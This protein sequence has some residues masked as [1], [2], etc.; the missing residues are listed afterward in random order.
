MSIT[1]ILTEPF[2]LRALVSALLLGPL[3]A[4]LGVFLTARRMAFF[5]DTI[6]HGAMTGIALGFW[7]GLTDPTLSMLCFSLLVAA[8]ILWL[9]EHTDLLPDTIM[10]L[11]LA[12]SVALGVVILSLL[13]G[14]YIGD[15]H[16]YLF[17]DILAVSSMD[18][19]LAAVL[20]VVIGVGVFGR[21]SELTLLTAHPEMAH[22]CGI[23]VRRLN[24]LFV[25]ALTLTVTLSVRLFGIILVTSLLV[26]P[27]AAARNIS[28]T[29]RQQILISLIISWV[30]AF[31]GLLASY[32]LNIASGATIVLTTIAIFF[33]SLPLGFWMRR[34]HRAGKQSDVSDPV[35]P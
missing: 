29:L 16:A 33:L 27:P 24:Y 23:P 8:A 32:H 26:V 20:V 21:L 35:S 34:R 12:G 10:A 13:R 22:V 31:V 18:L 2:L 14:S 15:L 17:G 11:L 25:L 1:V 6:A 3:C 19:G 9:Q 4:L 5:S 30:G 28:R 7:F